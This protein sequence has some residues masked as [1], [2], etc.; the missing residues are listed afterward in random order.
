MAMQ[1]GELDVHAKLCYG[2]VQV[3]ESYMQ[4]EI[5]TEQC[6]NKKRMHQ[7]NT[8]QFFQSFMHGS[9]YPVWY[10]TFQNFLLTSV[11]SR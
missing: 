7:W 3:S 1:L 11:T 5:G 9:R 6:C 4:F 8:K 10:M 2:D